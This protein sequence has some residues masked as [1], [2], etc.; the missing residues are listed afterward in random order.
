[1]KVPKLRFP[2]FKD[3]WETKR[4]GDIGENIIGLTYTP[5][6]VTD[7]QS[8]PIVLRSSNIQDN[9]LEFT[10][11]VRVKS[12]ISEK[13]FVKE[14]DILIC[15]RNGSKRLIGKNVLLPKL[16]HPATFGAFMSVFRSPQN[17][18]ISQLFSTQ[19]FNEQIQ[20][21]LGAT[22][23]QITT[24]NLNGF[25]FNFP[26]Q[27]EREK[28][29]SF[30]LMIDK[31]IALLSRQYQLYKSLKKGI[32]Y[33]IFNQE[34]KFKD[35]ENNPY[36]PWKE[37]KL[38][39]ILK[40]HRIT[41]DQ[42]QFEEVFSVAKSCGVVNQISHLGRSFASADI[43]NYKVVFPDDII[44]TKSP[45]SDFPFGIIKQNKTFRTGVVSVLYAVFTPKNKYLG[46]LLD[47][48]FTV[49]QNTHNYL[50]PITR[51]GAKNTINIG[52]QEFLDGSPIMLPTSEKEQKKIVEFISAVDVKI[53]VAKSQLELTK[54]YKQGLLQQMF[55]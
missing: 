11:I 1:M 21:N 18:F 28:I 50:K 7:E 35:E 6:N 52:N 8:C 12:K 19:R 40:E 39:E 43:S 16:E 3:S 4:I 10:D 51:R 13:L 55:V 42:N 26:S 41:N 45:T 23:N 46:S 34:L 5:K 48:Y 30:L 9:A 54:K 32:I 38:S 36:T 44:Y 31:K 33:K 29:A 15:T 2:E 22:I 20:V 37:M 49:W 53:A 17:K 25:K 24:K 14:D 27:Q 47:T